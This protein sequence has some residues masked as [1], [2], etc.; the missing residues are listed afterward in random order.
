[1]NPAAERVIDGTAVR[2]ASVAGPTLSVTFPAG[3]FDGV[4]RLLSAGYASRFDLPFSAVDDLQLAV[5]LVLRS[6]FR[7]GEHATLTFAE[8]EATLA[9]S[10]SPA[11]SDA[12]RRSHAYDSDADADL[13][14]L[15]ARLVDTV[16]AESEPARIVLRK[17]AAAS[18]P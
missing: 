17:A 3:R 4:A 15:L 1:M 6:A 16:T 14:S 9:L 18:R 2:S 13:G 12:L 11:G 10:I 8:E 5:E 7:P